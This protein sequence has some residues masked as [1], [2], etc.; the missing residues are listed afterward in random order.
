M[1]VIQ[2]MTNNLGKSMEDLEYEFGKL[3]LLTAF[4]SVL[5]WKSYGFTTKLYVDSDFKE[6]FSKFGLLEMYDEVDDTFLNNSDKIYEDKGISKTLFWSFSKLFILENEEE[7]VIISDMDFIPFE[8]YHKYTD[9]KCFAYYKEHL[10]EEFYPSSPDKYLELKPDYQFPDWYDWN[11]HPYNCAVTYINDSSLK[12]LYL[13]QAYEY[14][15]GIDYSLTERT[16]TNNIHVLFAE[17][18]NH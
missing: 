2:V 10:S 14:A 9:E 6:Y 18:K 5:K 13:N 3:S 11:C 8:D 12:E 16:L 7:P 1:K 17:Q 15:K 4:L